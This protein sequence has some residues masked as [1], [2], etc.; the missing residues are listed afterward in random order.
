MDEEF[1]SHAGCRI[2]M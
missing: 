2:S 1:V